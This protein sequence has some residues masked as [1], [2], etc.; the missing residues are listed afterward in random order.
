MSHKHTT[1]AQQYRYT[2][3]KLNY[4]LA[5]KKELA[6]RSKSTHQNNNAHAS[7]FIGRKSEIDK[8]PYRHGILTVMREFIVPYDEK[9]AAVAARVTQHN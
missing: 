9:S 7:H 3:K 6:T 5:S 8:N 1:V 2:K 4:G